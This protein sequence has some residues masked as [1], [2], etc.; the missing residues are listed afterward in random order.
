MKLPE[1]PRMSPT[2][3]LL[4]EMNTRA[5]RVLL[6]GGGDPIS[7]GLLLAAAATIQA[8]Q[9]QLHAVPVT[10]AEIDADADDDSDV[11]APAARKPRKARTGAE[12][13]HRFVDGR[14]VVAVGVGPA[15]VPCGKAK[16]AGGRG[17]KKPDQ[18]DAAA[19]TVPMPLTVPERSVAS[20]AAAAE[21]YSGGGMGSSGTGDR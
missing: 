2:D 21:R 11:A 13:R 16:G 6:I 17:N 1:P 8:Q 10:L 3:E 4:N 5:H 18:P 12:H 9:R 14:C 15:A 19:R 20:L 7:A